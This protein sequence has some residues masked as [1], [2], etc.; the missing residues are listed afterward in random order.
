MRET[1]FTPRV[2]SVHYGN[3]ITPV[4]AREDRGEGLGMKSGREKIPVQ[5]MI[6]HWERLERGR[7]LRRA[8]LV[9]QLGLEAHI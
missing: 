1:R 5:L 6:L 4:S 7:W 3:D 9:P 2:Q 8:V